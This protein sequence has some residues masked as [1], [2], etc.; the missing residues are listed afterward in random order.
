MSGKIGNIYFLVFISLLLEFLLLPPHAKSEPKHI[1][2]CG[3]APVIDENVG[4]ARA[5]ALSEAKRSAVEIGIGSLVS[6]Q[7]LVKNA[8][9]VSD[10]IYSQTAGYVTDYTIVSEGVKPGGETF[11]LCMDTMVDIGNIED[12]LRAIGILKRQIG[13]P[14]FMTVYIPESKGASGKDK[15][16]VQS[17]RRIIDDAFLGKGF[18]VL[19]K[20]IVRDF[21]NEAN[22]KD[23][24]DLNALS[25]MALE[26]QA[27]L[28]LLFDIEA[29]ERTDLS[30]KYFKEIRLTV[31]IRAVAPGTADI[32][33]T[34]G[35]S[36]TVRTSKKMEGDFLESPVIESDATKLAE[37][38]CKSLLEETLAYFERQSHE[39]IRYNCRFSGF[40]QKQRLAIVEVIEN[41]TG[42]TDKNMRRQSADS[43]ELDI[44]YFG[45]RFD[46]QRELMS[47]LTRK[48]IDVETK[49][50]QGNSFLFVKP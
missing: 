12:D 5:Q 31:D 24:A 40:S 48:G 47:A 41:M 46:F 27:D 23:A 35:E 15:I 16:V 36:K 4:R 14:R 7:T 21:I 2:A 33:G 49:E 37:Q 26:Y 13:N 19:D 1:H 43:L 45:K 29:T 18:I 44:D 32:I 38:V 42:V 25:A 8:V 17:V 22:K 28:I 3:V 34:E 9:L 20:M 10:R 30:N 50:S 11:E 39:G 6:A